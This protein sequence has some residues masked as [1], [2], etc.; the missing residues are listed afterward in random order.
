[1]MR[2]DTNVRLFGIR[3]SRY[4]SGMQHVSKTIPKRP[5]RIV[6]LRTD[7]G[8]IIEMMRT[9]EGTALAKYIDGTITV[10][11]TLDVDGRTLTPIPATNNL[12]AHNAVLLPE[13]P[14]AYGDISQLVAR[15]QA[16]IYRY[17][18]LS[19][20]FL[21]IAS[22]YVLLTWVYDAFNEL[23]Y[24]RLRG[25]YGSGKTRALLIIG[26]VTY[27]PFF[28][29]GASTVSPIFHTL[30]TF[31]GTLIVDEADFRFSDEKSELVKIFNNG[32]VRGFPV[33]RTA[34][35]MQKEFDPRAFVVF[36][37]KIVAMRKSFEDPALESRFL[38]EEMGQRTMR[39][40]IPINL[41]ECQK[42]EATQLR[43]Q[44]LMYRF[45]SVSKVAIDDTLYDPML[46]PRL[47]QIL[48]P[49]L[50]IVDDPGLRDDIRATLR[51]YD[52]R[53]YGE[54]AQ[55]SEAY[56][57]EVLRDLMVRTTSTVVPLAEI[58]TEFKKRYDGE[59]RD[60]ISVRQVSTLIRRNLR[61]Y[62]YKSHGI[63]VVPV[64]EREKVEALCVRYGVMDRVTPQSGD[65]RGT[66]GR[67]GGIP[68]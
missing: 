64:S 16:H 58:T 62:A 67:T 68:S 37:P 14:C 33:L 29:S 7:D 44:L 30:D 42:E 24:L 11:D 17:V 49:L 39:P 23:P 53:L 36:G 27:K 13:S 63:Y 66:W 61:L 10:T 31:R 25:D 40:G 21:K 34:L 22:W 5:T 54:R 2:G 35:T 47:N 18:D 57:L 4:A 43:N 38:T 26:S 28:A 19:P 48:I 20:Q 12:I 59:Y 51:S 55:S 45:E 56:L 50:S 65:E 15:I 3:G 32:N 6:S 52:E 46:S 41:P 8:T 60:P 1:M 9:T